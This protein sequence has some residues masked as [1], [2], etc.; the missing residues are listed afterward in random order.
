MKPTLFE[1][2]H[3]DPTS[4]IVDGRKAMSHHLRNPFDVSTN[5]V[6]T[7]VSSRAWISQPVSTLKKGEVRF[8]KVPRKDTSGSRPLTWNLTGASWHGREARVQVAFENGFG[9][10]GSLRTLLALHLVLTPVCHSSEVL[11]NNGFNHGFL[12]WCWADF[13]H[14]PHI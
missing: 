9:G 2:D 13:L 10:V 3:F 7:M 8:F 12:F 14:P 1:F 4:H 11:S 6:S 5:M